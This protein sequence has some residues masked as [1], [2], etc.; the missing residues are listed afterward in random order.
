RNKQRG[1]FDIK[2]LIEK[3]RLSDEIKSRSVK[4]FESL[5][6]AEAKIHRK[7]LPD[8]R[9]HEVGALDCIIDVVGVLSGLELLGV[10]RVIASKIPLG[11]G[12]VNFHHGNL[13]LPAP[14]TVE[15][16]K[17]VPVH[18]APVEGELVTPTGAALITNLTRDFG[19]LP[20]MRIE[21]VGYGVGEK[22]YQNHPNLL[23]IILGIEE[24]KQ[25]KE[26]RAV[27]I[28][29]N[30]DNMNPELY[31]NLIEKLFQEGAL[32]VYLTNIQMKKARPGIKLSVIARE[33]HRTKLMDTIFRESTSIGIRFYPVGR[34]KLFR[35][36]STVETP[37]GKVRV[38]VSQGKKGIMNLVP[39]YDD[40]KK[41]AKKAG[42][43]LKTI[44]SEVQG[45]LAQIKN[46]TGT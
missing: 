35:R 7:R 6:R 36:V 41:L 22:D 43:P 13:P 3:S 1:F 27:V 11:R 39:E 42:I 37:H 12:W 20:S 45:K 31:D 25:G 19:E 40:C 32:D 9:F 34:H 29:S 17:E 5:A 21:R 15:I 30:I 26:E 24:G 23:R 44:Y 16:L 38:K 33:E 14:A 8:L 46:L 4:V 10:N 18:P 28:E 2:G